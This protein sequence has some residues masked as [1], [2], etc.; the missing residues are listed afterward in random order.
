MRKTG[1]A[2][3]VTGDY[4]LIKADDVNCACLYWWV[5]VK[6]EVSIY[7]FKNHLW[8]FSYIFCNLD[9]SWLMNV[10]FS[11]MH[12]L[13]FHYS[14]A[15]LIIHIK[16]FF[17]KSWTHGPSHW[18]MYLFLL[19]PGTQP[20]MATPESTKHSSLSCGQHVFGGWTDKKEHLSM[21]P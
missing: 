3:R 8:K 19:K 12:L 4:K 17:I 14:T 2:F 11:F 7:N 5:V 13:C 21:T 6:K 20:V 18:S 15:R 1:N 10:R 16:I 9:F